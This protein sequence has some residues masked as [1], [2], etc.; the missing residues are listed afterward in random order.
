MCV[1]VCGVSSARAMPGLLC[2]PES[3]G[4]TGEHHGGA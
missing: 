2:V 3:E 4:E 1:C